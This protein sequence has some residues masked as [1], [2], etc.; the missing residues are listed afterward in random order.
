MWAEPVVDQ[1]PTVW[2]PN[3][4]SLN[5][6]QRA[7]VILIALLAL[8]GAW[9]TLHYVAAESWVAILGIVVCVVLLG[10]VIGFSVSSITLDHHE[11]TETGAW[12]IETV[13]LSSVVEVHHRQDVRSRERH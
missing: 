10:A 1:T 2:L 12:R 6:V 8:A 4:L 3:T 5:P 13:P 7:C 9:G 11:Y